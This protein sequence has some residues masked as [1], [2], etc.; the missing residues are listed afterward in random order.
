MDDRICLVVINFKKIMLQ[1]Q[2]M[3]KENV[4]FTPSKD[5]PTQNHLLENIQG[6]K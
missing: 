6:K 5:I 1:K 3:S 2:L 4:S